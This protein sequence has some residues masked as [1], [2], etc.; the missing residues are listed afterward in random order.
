MLRPGSA[1]A[2]WLGANASAHAA[3]VAHAAHKGSLQLARQHG[4]VGELFEGVPLEG[5]PSGSDIWNSSL[6]WSTVVEW[7]PAGVISNIRGGE[8]TW[9]EA[10]YVSFNVLLSLSVVAYP[11]ALV[12]IIISLTVLVSICLVAG[13]ASAQDSHGDSEFAESSDSGFLQRPPPIPLLDVA[14]LPTI[15]KKIYALWVQFCCC[16]PAVTVF[17]LPAVLIF[18]SWPR[19]QEVF[20]ILTMLTTACI[21]GNGMYMAIFAF[22]S[23][24]K[25]RRGIEKDGLSK[26]SGGFQDAPELTGHSTGC[27][28]NA[29]E[30]DRPVRI[31][32]VLQWVIIPQYTED[33]DIVA[34]TLESIA[35]NRLARTS[36]CVVLAMEEREA[37]SRSKVAELEKKF[38]GRFLEMFSTYHPANLPN[39]PPGKASNT[40]WAF[41]ELERHLGRTCTASHVLLTIS[42]ADS[43][44]DPAYFEALSLRYLTEDPSKRQFTLWQSPIFHVKNYHRQPAPVLVGTMFTALFEMAAMSDPNAVRFPYSTY[45]MS[46]SLAQRVGGWDPQWIAEDWHMGLKCFLLTFGRARVETI[47]LP[48]LNYTPEETTWCGTVMAR[49]TQAKRHALGFSDLSYYFMTLPLLFGFAAREASSK[50]NSRMVQDI[51]TTLFVGIGIIVKIV[52]VHVLLGITCTYGLI[53]FLLSVVMKMIFSEDRLLDHFFD[54]ADFCPYMLISMSGVCTMATTL[55]W[56]YV[57]SMLKDRIEPEPEGSKRWAFMRPYLHY[58]HVLFSMQIFGGIFFGML[59]FATM[60]A[61]YATM[62]RHDLKYEVASKPTKETR[63]S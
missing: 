48:T 35:R 28:V 33:V 54:R 10:S 1:L 20:S 19:P 57:Y 41:T 39:D 45:S 16:I 24:L 40:A 61:A 26:E 6:S 4:G 46:F 22:I 23:I 11:A 17:G 47:M 8:V 51:L 44:F 55:M 12:T 38:S 31:E 2:A 14:T 52:N 34:N 7:H 58:L 5:K 62:M 9:H 27:S 37:T 15:S 21:Y 53:T 29:S 32:D 60:K 30:T 36:I 43:E 25:L 18:L 42:D 13:G 50:G 3:H 56:I 59:A 49:W 63:A